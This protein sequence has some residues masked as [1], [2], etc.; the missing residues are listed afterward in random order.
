MSKQFT[1]EEFKNLDMTT[2]NNLIESNVSFV[3]AARVDLG[4]SLFWCSLRETV[5]RKNS[6]KDVEIPLT[7]KERSFLKLLIEQKETYV[8][9]KTIESIIWKGKNASIYTIRNFVNKIRFKTFYEIIKTKSNL[10]YT[11]G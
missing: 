3:V 2:I 6:K 8:D 9:Y 10:G 4:K 7:K 1:P 11:I 5:F